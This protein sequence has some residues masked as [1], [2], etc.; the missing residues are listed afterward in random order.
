[1][2]VTIKASLY[3]KTW[4]GDPVEIRRFS[5]GEV[6][7][8]SYAYLLE[9][10]AK[11]FP[12]VTA[13]NITLAWIDADGDTITISSDE[14]LVL[15]LEHFKGNLF[16]LYIKRE[17]SEPAATSSDHQKDELQSNNSA[18]PEQRGCFHPGVVCDGCNGPIYGTRFKCLMCSDYDLCSGCEGKGVHVNHN[19]IGLTRP[20]HFSPWVHAFGPYGGCGSSSRGGGGGGRCGG[21]WQ[22][23]PPFHGG[24]NGRGGRGGSGGCPCFPGQGRQ[25]RPERKPEEGQSETNGAEPESMDTEQKGG[26]SEED[27]RG[28]LRGVGEAVSNFLEP[29]GV[30]VDVDVFGGDGSSGR[31]TAE[32]KADDDTSSAA[33]ATSE[34][35]VETALAQLKSMGYEDEGGWLTELVRAKGG[36]VTKV[37]DAL[38]PAAEEV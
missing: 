7:A 14:E 16:R 23:S 15:A 18:K 25:C 9:Q 28:F 11:V 3:N 2:S 26:P 27:R 37:L 34:E 19:M 17:A 35:V 8:K 33:T 5:V 36:D 24:W 12:S 31:K 1:M 6:A 29:F 13:E 30:K 22:G 20:P 38:H 4:R 32:S 10:L 21:R